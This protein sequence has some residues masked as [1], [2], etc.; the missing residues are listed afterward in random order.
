MLFP[1]WLESGSRHVWRPYCQHQTAPPPLAVIG[2]LGSRLLL[3]DGRQLVDG[4][5]SWWT[6]AHG[7]RHPHIIARMEEQLR[8]LPHVAFG[9]LANEPAYSLAERLAALF[10]PLSRVFFVES[11]SVSVEVALK[12]AVQSFHNRGQSR[13][14][15]IVCFD[16]AYHGD[17]LATMA[18][19]PRVE[20]RASGPIAVRIAME[21]RFHER[22][23]DHLHDRLRHAIPHRGDA[24][25]ARASVSFRGSPRITVGHLRYVE[26]AAAGRLRRS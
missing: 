17:T 18:L 11:G 21:L 6:A 5:A 20:R 15:R 13:R 25:W 12:M 7:Y 24:E 14:R 4:I 23:E 26:G 1:P 16:D 19:S 10:A 8:H 2:A 9:G 3:A 22:F